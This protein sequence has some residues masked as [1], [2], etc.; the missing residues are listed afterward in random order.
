MKKFKYKKKILFSAVQ[1]TGL[2][3][4]ANYLSVLKHW[5]FMQNNYNCMFCVADLHSITN[6]NNNYN[7]KKKTLDILAF[8]LACGIDPN[9][10]IIFVQSSVKE[11]CYMNWILN[12]FSYFGELSRMTQFKNKS[13][14]KKVINMGLLNYPILMSSDILLYNSSYVSIGNDQFQH[15]ELTRKIARRLN[16]IFGKIFN[17][18]KN[19]IFKQGS[20]I[21][22]LLD[23][24]KKMSKSDSNIKNSIFLLDKKV[25]IFKKI[26]S[27]TTDSDN[28]PKII[29]DKK[30]KPGIS[31]LLNIFSILSD[32]TIL[33]SEKIFMN[34]TYSDF[35]NKLSHVIYKELHEIQKNFFYFRNRENYLIYI[36]N[37]GSIQASKIAKKMIKIINNKLSFL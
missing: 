20:K 4:L 14:N 31:N 10:S 13:K 27:S 35:K 1:P 24:K 33:E 28:P 23:P 5:K 2:L 7:L 37:K 8:Y 22:S 21:M 32:K 17:V 3:T 9:K 36:S 19:L 12:C 25:D 29:Y 6:F 16:K 26:Q 30:S 11:H 34:Y 18:P 15:L